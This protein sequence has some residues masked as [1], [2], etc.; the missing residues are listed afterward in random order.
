VYHYTDEVNKTQSVTNDLLIQNL[1]ST[2]TH[3]GFDSLGY[4]PI[5]IGTHSICSGAAMALVL[6]GHAAWRIML[7]GR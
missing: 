6:L 5:D 2:V 4:Q 1:W 3:L 7:T